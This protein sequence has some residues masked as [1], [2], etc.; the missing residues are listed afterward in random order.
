MTK[1]QVTIKEKLSFVPCSQKG[2][3]TSEGPEFSFRGK[4]NLVSLLPTGAQ[5]LPS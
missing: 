3:G 2:L 1:P 4:V 5:S